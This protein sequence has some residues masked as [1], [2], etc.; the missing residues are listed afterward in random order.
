MITPLNFG[1]GLPIHPCTDRPPEGYRGGMKLRLISG[2][3]TT[4]PICKITVHGIKK[5]DLYL[6]SEMQ[7]EAAIRQNDWIPPIFQM[8]K[9][10]KMPEGSRELLND[11]IFN[12]C[13]VL[14]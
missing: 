7:Q 14:S 13:V 8:E 4:L 11:Y 10:G 6:L 1:V 2:R 5:M 3:E 9:P 12:G